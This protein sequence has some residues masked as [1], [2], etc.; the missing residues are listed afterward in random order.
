MTGNK[1]QIEPPVG[2]DFAIQRL[3][4][5]LFTAVSWENVQM[6]GRID[7]IPN[8][9]IKTAFKP[10]A[11]YSEMDYKPVVRDDNFSANIFFSC[12]DRSPTK[13]GISY[14]NE[15]KIIVMLDLSRTHPN[16]AR[17]DNLAQNEMVQAISQ[18]TNFIL[19]SIGTG[20]KEC[21]G[22]FDTEDIKFT[23]MGKNHVFCLTGNINY[24]ITC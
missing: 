8:A 11:Y 14:I 10:F 9:E 7:K 22:E 21:L 3:Q 16:T 19:T 2:I 13:E 15:M 24:Q 1:Y 23:D 20:M 5:L 6:F 12:S 17:A 18:Q 4:N